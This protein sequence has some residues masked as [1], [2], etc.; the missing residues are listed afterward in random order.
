MQ[1]CVA[2]GKELLPDGGF[3]LYNAKGNRIVR[4]PFLHVYAIPSTTSIARWII[5]GVRS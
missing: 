1:K 4:F 3:H 5:C 2:L